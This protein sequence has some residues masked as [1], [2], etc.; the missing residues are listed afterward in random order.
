MRPAMTAAGGS[1]RENPLG[2]APILGLMVK[3]AI[4]SVMGMLVSAAYNITDQVFIGNIVGMLGN[5]ATN[6]AF[7]IFFLTSGL[8]QLVGVGMAANFSISLGAKKEDRARRF[9][10]TGL[11]LAVLAGLILLILAVVF[12][13]PILL[14]GGATETVYPY[15]LAYFSITA[16]GLPFHL[17]SMALSYLIRSDGSPMFA[18]ITT[19]SGAGLNI[20][21][22]WLF[23][24]VL[25]WG[26]RGAAIATVIGQIVSAALCVFYLTRFKAFRLH[27]RDLGLDKV[28]VPEILK[29]GV[30]NFINHALMMVMLVILNNLLTH[31]GAMTEFGS[32]IPLAVAGVSSKLNTILVAFNVGI[33]LGCQPIWGFNLGAKQY[34]RVK[35]TYKKG[36]LASL[37][38]GLV[39]LCMLQLFP[40]PIFALFGAGDELYFR[41]AERYLRIYYLM[42]WAHGIQPMSVNY[43]TGT[44]N[45]KHGLILT[46]SRQGFLLIPL[47]LILPL[48]LGLDG[49]LFASPI[50]DAAASVLSLALVAHSFKLLK[51]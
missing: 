38:I 43:F 20:L 6:V 33:A 51:D 36:V 49:V 41:F 37:V 39:F 10:T 26:I 16:I 8:S 24:A 12:R 31:Y 14:M 44:G 28:Y 47:L 35:E 7:P 9:V 15:A 25:G 19:A 2:S 32:D 42:V 29:L 17:F 18:M 5:A 1:P 11:V 22:D 4:P 13:R 50:A 30:A 48:F 27:F 46:F 40:R 21:L 34:D 3:F 23:M 45:V